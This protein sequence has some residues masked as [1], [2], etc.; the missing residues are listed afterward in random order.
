MV[1]Y[2]AV[3]CGA[4]PSGATAAKYMAEKGLTILLLDKSS[5]P[6][7]KPCGGA[8]RPINIEEFEYLKSGIQKIPHVICKRVKMYSPSLSHFVDY[9]PN[10]AVMYNVQRK[11]FDAMLVNYAKDA[12]AEF[13]ENA[14]VKNVK[15]KNDGHYLQLQNGK[16][17]SG[18]VVIGAGGMHDPVAR[19]LRKKE[20]LPEKWPKS[21]IGLSV[22]AEYEV[23]GDFII[24]RYGEEFASYFHLKP[25]NLYGYAWTFSKRDA[26]NIGFGAYWADMKKV[27]IGKQYA[28]YLALLRKEKLIPKDL[29]QVK[30]KGGLIPLRGAIKTSYSD[31]MLL[32][33]DAAGFVSPIGGDGIFYGMCSGRI[34]AEVV[35]YAVERGSYKKDIL[36]RYQRK[37]YTQWGEDLK[38]LCY[39]ADKISAKTE[40]IIK[41][42]S[43]DEILRNMCVGLYNGECRANMIKGK[44]IRR[45]ARDFLKYDIL[46]MN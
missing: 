29:L 1:K 43:R 15:A 2:D 19:F 9:N 39:F 8:L 32:I 23:P 18:K 20:G 27:D 14:M 5:F 34:A 33:G 44:I 37:W 46:K 35:N 22:V 45:M 17:I 4:G 13:L 31:G 21:E 36:S 28:Q 16:E 24:D 12:G 25:N 38:V 40:Q 3:I 6:R 30:P 7:D 11:H 26:L 10:K 41:Y 42:A